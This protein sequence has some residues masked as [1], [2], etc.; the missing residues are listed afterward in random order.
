V[1]TE[2]TGS[3]RVDAAVVDVDEASFEAAV[4]RRSASVPVV[5]DFWAPWCGPCRMIGPVLERLASEAGGAW[6]L[7]KLN[8]DDSPA[9]SARYGIQ[10]IPAV[11][12]FRDG[13]V[14]DEFVGAQPEPVIRQFLARI[15]P[16]RADELVRQGGQALSAGRLDD[17]LRHFDAALS[18]QPDHPA[19]LL[20]RGRVRLEQDDPDGA[21][22]ALERV[23]RAARERTEAEGWLAQA[24]FRR[25]AAL[26]GGEIEAR[27][28][29]AADPGDVEA[30]LALAAALAAKAGY[31]EALEN[32][33]QLVERGAGRERAR[34]A[35]L[36]IFR[37]LGDEHALTQEYRPRLAALLW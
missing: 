1:A 31:R 19:A 8:V 26:T 32:L 22:A 20:G 33:L 28:R 23:G 27:R 35:I 15:L 30:R 36:D 29:V 7:A 2:R 34:E 16:S 12:A 24:R 17:A 10:G 13:R 3:E 9:L 21:V 25:D 11:K 18:E 5:V 14:V 37:V 6:Q 4:L